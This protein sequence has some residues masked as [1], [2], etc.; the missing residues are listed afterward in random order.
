[1]ES[2]KTMPIIRIGEYIFDIIFYVI[3][4]I[5]VFTSVMVIYKALMYPDKI[6][7]IFSYKPFI[8][9][10]NSI[11][12]GIEYGDLAITQMT[13]T[14][15]INSGDII[16]FRDKDD[17]III[18]KIID[19]KETDEGSSF[20]IENVQNEAANSKYINGKDIEGVLVNKIPGIGTVFM[21]LQEPIVLL[22]I[23][24]IILIIGAISY[25]IADKLDKKMEKA[26]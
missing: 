14:E 25:Y 20:I 17:F 6:P 23:I 2:K 26:D 18:K 24:I 22:I 1:M 8:I 13:N 12:E 19:I 5:I 15:K 11:E 4:V 7:D 16:A 10:D 9:L 21:Y 3:A